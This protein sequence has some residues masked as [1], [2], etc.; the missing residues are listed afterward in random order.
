MNK[1]WGEVALPLQH[2]RGC[3]ST[4]NPYSFSG[5]V[6]LCHLFAAGWGSGLDMLRASNYSSLH[7]QMIKCFII[8]CASKVRWNVFLPHWPAQTHFFFPIMYLRRQL[9][10]LEGTFLH[11]QLFPV[12]NWGRIDKSC[13]TIVCPCMPLSFSSFLLVLLFCLLQRLYPTMSPTPF[14]SLGAS[15]IDINIVWMIPN[16]ISQV[17]CSG[18][19]S[20]ICECERM[21]KGI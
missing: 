7:C 17:Y 1:W 8:K 16:S 6:V 12:K 3:Y 10:S 5:T 18:L 21:N 4:L 9:P 19:C 13:K 20:I 15:G 11:C 2:K 14:L